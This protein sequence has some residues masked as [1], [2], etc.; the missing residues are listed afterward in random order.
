MS[1]L[2]SFNRPADR[3]LSDRLLAEYDLAIGDLVYVEETL[4]TE[5]RGFVAE[6]RF[7][8]VNGIG[9]ACVTLVGRSFW[10][11]GSCAALL[12][13]REREYG[14]R[15]VEKIERLPANAWSSSNGERN[16]R[17]AR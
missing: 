8:W 11:P 5:R 16:W 9:D 2:M 4:R 13:G 14:V 15:I 12:V 10:A 17:E 3:T 1:A 6:I 7:G